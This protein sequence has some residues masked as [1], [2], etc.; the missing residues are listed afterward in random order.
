MAV[1]GGGKLTETPFDCKINQLSRIKFL[2]SLNG[3]TE[4]YGPL[5]PGKENLINIAGNY[6]R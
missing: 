5:H 4:Y 6:S 2:N 1:M 3:I